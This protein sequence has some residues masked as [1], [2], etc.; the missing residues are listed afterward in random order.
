MTHGALDDEPSSDDQLAV[1]HPI[2]EC[3]LEKRFVVPALG[4]FTVSCSAER[5][6][7]YTVQVVCEA[8]QYSSIAV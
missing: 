5:E 4:L 1:V 3:A 7:D 2:Y 6:R 8:T